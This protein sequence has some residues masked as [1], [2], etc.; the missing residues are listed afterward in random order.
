M[1]ISGAPA[2]CV[3]R[4]LVAASALIEEQGAPL[5]SFAAL[6]YRAESDVTRFISI[7]H[8]LGYYSAAAK[9]SYERQ[10]PMGVTIE[11][12]PGPVYP[13]DSVRVEGV[14]SDYRQYPVATFTPACLGL[15]IGSAA[16]SQRIL[17]AQRCLIETMV[18]Q[19]YPL[20]RVVD[21]QIVVD[22]AEEGVSITFIIDS[23]PFCFFGST[24]VTGLRC[25][26]RRFVL[27]CLDWRYGEPYNRCAITR[28][29]DRLRRANLFTSINI[30]HDDEA[31]PGGILGMNIA[32]RE[33][34]HRTITLGVLYSLD[35]GAGGLA[36]WQHRNL[37]GRGE[38]LTLRALAAQKR[39]EGEVIYRRPHF[40]HCD[41]DLVLSGSARR[42][43]ILPYGERALLLHARVERRFW[44]RA[45]YEYGIKGEQLQTFRSDNDGDFTL[46]SA[47]MAVWVDT[48]ND[49]LNPIRGWRFRLFWE[50]TASLVEER[51][52]F[53]K[54]KATLSFYYPVDRRGWTVV[55][56][57]ATLG[58]IL[59]ASDFN[60]PPPRRF[61][62]GSDS[63]LRGYR[64][65]SVSP[66]NP[67]TWEILGGRSI[68]VG[69]VELRQRIGQSWGFVLF[70]DVGNV[71]ETS[72]PQLNRKQ[73]N[74]VGFGPRYYTGLGPFSLDIAFPLNRRPGIDRYFEVYVNV[75]QTF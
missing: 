75:G 21:R 17:D 38:S 28:T 5:P 44:S 67:V 15:P 25:V 35:E 65:Q 60:I 34:K 58:T 30:T 3:E 19:G 40:V 48:T 12:T 4:A 73:L 23:G 14:E 45:W 51:V 57:Y 11:I 9:V 54:Q 50:P 46:L 31:E 8:A 29:I 68:A 18:E 6:Q 32:L 53:T 64:Y 27:E 59:G 2:P 69:G 70:Y 74:S 61:Y 42:V 33:R 72:W 24:D 47:P 52:Y 7:L 55:A 1:E 49:L 37:T 10:E 63:E 66:L 56:A 36:Q 20:A 26:R 16:V 43:D 13:I 39:Q 22:A 62:S 41:Q 71:Y